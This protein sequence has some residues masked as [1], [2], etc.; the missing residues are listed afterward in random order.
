MTADNCRRQH[1]YQSIRRVKVV[2]PSANLAF[3]TCLDIST[4][5]YL[6]A[7]AV[8]SFVP[9]PVS[10]FLE[11]WRK[12]RAQSPLTYAS[13]QTPQAFENMG[14][15]LMKS[16][17]TAWDETRFLIARDVKRQP[18][19][20]VRLQVSL[21][22]KRGIEVILTGILDLIAYSEIALGIVDVK[23]ARSMP[24]PSFAM[25]ADQLTMYQLMLGAH[26]ELLGLPSV[27]W[28]A[29]WDF[30]KLKSPRIEPPVCVPPRPVQDL[31]EFREKMFW[32][33]EDIAR[34][35]F[36]K[37]SRMQHNTPCDECDF[38]PACI[39]DDEEGLLFRG[40]DPKKPA[41]SMAA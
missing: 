28:L 15:D 9:D 4:R 37:A 13:T 27:G 35:R 33:A 24:T 6:H 16:F 26:R 10:R 5:E 36:P 12:A 8:D 14:V 32:L 1:W 38:A 23:S 18:L 20:N 30:L 39:T 11:L 31:C 25:R 29:F 21:G 22:T 3:G 2:A 19:L 17:P 41:L 34:E 40:E 7:I